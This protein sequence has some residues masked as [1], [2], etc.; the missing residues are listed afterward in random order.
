MLLAAGRQLDGA[1]A[2]QPGGDHL[3]FL[4]DHLIVDPRAAAADQAAGVGVAGRQAREGE[5]AE[6][7][8][9]GCEFG[10]GDGDRGQGGGRLAFLERL[11]GGFGGLRRLGGAVGERGCLGGEDFLGLV[12]LRAAKGFQAGDLSQRQVGEQAQ[13]AADVGVLGVAPELP[14]VVGA[15]AGPR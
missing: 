12:D 14:V 15:T 10:R 6:G 4:G 5:Q 1:V 13:E 9:A 11:A 7:G 8:D 3:A 2:Q